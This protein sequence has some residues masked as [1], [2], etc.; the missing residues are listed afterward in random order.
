MPQKQAPLLSLFFI[1]LRL[2]LTSF[3]G[4]VAHL[5]YF[6][7]EFVI[8]RKWLT[9]QAYADLVALCQF[10]PGPA[11][12]Q[13]G[14][15]IGYQRHGWAGGIIAWSAF[16]LP[17]AIALILFAYGLSSIGDAS[18]AGWVLGLKLAAVA[19]VA[20]AVWGMGIKLCNT[21]TTA[22]FALISAAVILL[23]PTAWAQVGVVIAGAIAGWLLLSADTPDPGH[24]ATGAKRSPRAGCLYVALFAALLL[25][26][27]GL[28]SISDSRW[29]QY[30]DAFY[31][32]GSLVF[33]GGHV[34]L[35]LLEEA[36]VSTGWVDENTFL[37]G[38]GAAQAV[39][40]PLFTFS[41]FLGASMDRSP[42][43]W[44][45]GLYCLVVI[46][47]PSIL[48]VTGILPF[49]EKIRANRGARRA[50][51]GTNAAVVG[52]LLAAFYDP[53]WTSAIV[54][55]RAAAFAVIAYL[56]IQFWKV[57]AW[58]LVILSGLVGWA[59]L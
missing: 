32:S 37:A 27:W 38:Y 57:P 48:L 43:G 49:W 52:L 53:V 2:G 40:G 17:S 10:L 55:P 24:S 23:F 46:Y 15:A 13:V 26:F 5:G 41:A 18:D 20:K 14:Y 56:L 7:D 31:R 28:S 19:V 1:Y 4:P 25:G 21:R 45:G 35:P 29:V 3:G 22:S 6:R 54:S 47:I 9:D 11:S 58:A 42:T 34:V 51:A 50:L 39:P 8:R 33:G 44:L 16:T 12:S 30:F 36:V 59:I